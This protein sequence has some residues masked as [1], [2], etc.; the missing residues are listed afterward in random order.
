MLKP[1]LIAKTDAKA[2]KEQIRV[3][4]GVRITYLTARLIRVESG[5]FTDSAS[6]AVWNRNFKAGNM[7]V[8]RRGRKIIV[9]TDECIFTIKN[10]KPYSVFFKAG[11]NTEVF[12]KQ[13]N[14]KGTCRT[15]D[16]TFGRV[17]LEDG[18]ITKNGAYLLEDSSMLLDESG[19]FTA[20][21][22]N[23][24]DYYAFAYGKNY[25]ETIRAF[26]K[27]S[28]PVPLI[29]RFALG[30]WWSRYHA[31]TQKE[32][33]DLMARFKAEGIPLTVATVDM[34]WHWVRNI[35]KRFG[36]KY[37]GWTGYSWDTQLFPNYKEFLQRLKEDNLH[38]TLN[39]HPADG[40]HC[41][42]DMYEDMAKAVGIDPKTKQKVDF[43]CGSDDFWNAYF[44][45]LHKPYEKDG[46]DFWWI[47]WQQG[48]KS[49]VKGLD[50]LNA[51]NHYHFLDNAE[52]GQMPMILSR[53]AGIGSH[54]YP[55]GFSGDTAINWKV[56]DFQPYFTIN[57]NNAAY[58]WWSHD[59][60][61]HHM[62]YRDDDLYMRWLQFGV[63]SPIMRLHSTAIEFLGKEPWKY[64]AE[65]YR[66]A[67]EWLNLRH[68][69]IPYIFTMDYRTHKDGIALCEPMYYSY[70]ENEK[71]FNV[72]NQYMFGS[73]LMVCPI[74]KPQHKEIN[75]GS[76]R[77]WIP[78]G[79]WTDIFTNQSYDGEQELTLFRDIDT[80][81]VLAKEGAIIPMS[82]DE[83]NSTD[84]PKSFEIWAFSG[85]GSFE[86][87][88]DNAK[89]DYDEHMAKTK[90]SIEYF[91][92]K[93]TFTV[94]KAEGDL[95]VLPQKR[96]YR[97]VIKDIVV[98]GKPL[99]FEFN[100]A[101]I[102]ETHCQSAENAVRLKKEWPRDAV[103]RIVSRWQET[104][105]KKNRAYKP[106]DNLTT[107][108]DIKNTLKNSHFPK[109]VAGAIEEFLCQN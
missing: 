95:S 89:T 44:D 68:R 66:F 24:K 108:E 6:Y 100:D 11:G 105:L 1:S 56:L 25:R 83:G 64:K 30:V 7:K 28:S 5:E 90:F 49:D 46:V 50:P 57:A 23:S 67:K 79:R 99:V 38:I 98:D 97:V 72:A 42:E 21:G 71:A 78:K 101:D 51:L 45:I 80:I 36:V 60:G 29:P 31:Y 65:V 33:L 13:K 4:D 40:V 12:K 63:F 92:N 3:V 69:L 41:Y 16:M 52:S 15:L 93:L 10:S 22:D 106:F 103:I 59:I 94:S 74:T 34:D 14:L 27:I 62:G 77:A 87:I 8:S 76:V 96:N 47:D 109:T 2:N 86:L 55:L 70:P 39:L 17:P 9:E 26:Y 107:A 91:E 81:P 54:R 84:N 48:K 61:G 104:T 73:E 75:M 20:R 32:Y 37:G 35:E 19:H 85:N 102:N 18:F 88:E 58:T 82:A 53:Y 43:R